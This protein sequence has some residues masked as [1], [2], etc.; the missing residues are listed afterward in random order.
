MPQLKP[1]QATV[2][3]SVLPRTVLV[4]CTGNSARSILAEAIFNQRGAGQLTAYSAGSQPK[5]EPN[6]AALSLLSQ[7]G[8][9]TAFARSKSWDEFAGSGAPAIDMVVTVCDSAASE[10]CPV[11]PGHPMSVH[12]GIPDPAAVTGSASDVAQ[13]FELA[14]RRL[15]ARIA[16]FMDLPFEHLT[17]EAL[18]DAVR[19]IGRLDGATAKASAA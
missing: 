14:Y 3:G 15:D 10:A 16:A 5:G 8:L 7:R 18:K 2:Q 6:P 17:P 13:A 19:E 12:W 1:G 9:D 11:W 4:L